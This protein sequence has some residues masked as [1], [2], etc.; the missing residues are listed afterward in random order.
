MNRY[1]SKNI[2]EYAETSGEGKDFLKKMLSCPELL[3][4]QRINIIELNTE[5]K[6]I[7]K[8]AAYDALCYIEEEFKYMEKAKEICDRSG[9]SFPAVKTLMTYLKLI[10]DGKKSIPAFCQRLEFLEKILN[11]GAGTKSGKSVTLSTIHSSKGL[12]YDCVFVVDMVEGEFPGSRSIEEMERNSDTQL[13]EEERRLFFVAITRAKTYLHIFS[14]Q[15]RNEI[16]AVKSRFIDEME[17]CMSLIE[18]EKFKEGTEINHKLYGKG[19]IKTILNNGKYG[20]G[21]AARIDFNGVTRIIDLKV[22]VE[23]GII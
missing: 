9:Y 21:T 5:F 12:E 11:G 4:Y 16:P 23:K 20:G 1:I 7:S 15:T 6:K 22:C 10:A 17:R 2:V 14:I 18:L 19:I 8:M 3:P 13:L